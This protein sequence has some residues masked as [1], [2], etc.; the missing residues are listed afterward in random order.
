[1]KWDK[2]SIRGLSKLNGSKLILYSK[3]LAL[4]N[5]LF[6]SRMSS[7]N[8]S[9]LSSYL[10]RSPTPLSAKPETPTHSCN[11]LIRFYSVTQIPSITRSGPSVRAVYRPLIDTSSSCRPHPNKNSDRS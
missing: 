4:F 11:L 7:S 9:S 3:I 1:M 2:A 6:A 5:K 8:L 10:I